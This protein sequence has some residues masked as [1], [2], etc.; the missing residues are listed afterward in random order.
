M[1]SEM[2]ERRPLDLLAAALLA[3]V[4]AS[5]ACGSSEDPAPASPDAVRPL[6]V[7][8]AVPAVVVRDVTGEP[9][10]LAEAVREQGALLVFYR[11]GW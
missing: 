9:V 5:T 8:A 1:H 11:G 3:L 6:A 10:D 2:R 7:G 4:A